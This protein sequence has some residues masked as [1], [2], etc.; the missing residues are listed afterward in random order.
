MSSLEEL[1]RD[2]HRH[3]ELSGVELRTAGSS[4][5]GSRPRATR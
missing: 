4:P 3:P 1:Y 2:L 5:H